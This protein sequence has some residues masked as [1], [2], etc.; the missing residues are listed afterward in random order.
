MAAG[1]MSA[2]QAR[3]TTLTPVGPEAPLETVLPRRVAAS[4]PNDHPVEVVQQAAAEIRREVAYM[5]QALDAIESHLGPPKAV[6][7]PTQQ[8]FDQVQRQVEQA[9]DAKFAADMAAKAAAAQAQVFTKDDEPTAPKTSWQCPTH[10]RKFLKVETSR[11][12]RIYGLCTEC[13][14]FEK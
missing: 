14:E 6:P 9:A 1:I 11:K 8:A 13:R 10:G 5:L 7:V 2:K 4:F 12:G 3:A